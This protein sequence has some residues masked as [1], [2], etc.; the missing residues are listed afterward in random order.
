MKLTLSV[1]LRYGA[2]ASEITQT[3]RC[4]YLSSRTT[5]ITRSLML[6][7]EK[8]II[9]ITIAGDS[10]AKFSTKVVCG[11]L[12]ISGKVVSSVVSVANI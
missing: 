1:L 3:N 12:V 5:L 10:V 4:I 2:E 8:Q 6:L 9:P 7:G 11:T